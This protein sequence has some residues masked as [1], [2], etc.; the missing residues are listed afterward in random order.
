MTQFIPLAAR[1]GMS[2]QES[3]WD[4]DARRHLAP[5]LMD[6][7]PDD[8]HR[9]VCPGGGAS[10][11]PCL[12]PYTQAGTYLCDA[13][14][15][16]CWGDRAGERV[17]LVDAYGPSFTHVEPVQGQPPVAATITK[18]EWAPND[19]RR[20]IHAYL[21]TGRSLCKQSQVADWATVLRLAGTHNELPTCG[22]CVRLNGGAAS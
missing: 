1:Y 8:A 16:H 9:C 12:H 15:E 21:S 14:R 17:R 7:V 19:Q 3:F 6:E 22:N 10:A 20:R 5:T 11:L 4:M 2:T 13:C 18:I